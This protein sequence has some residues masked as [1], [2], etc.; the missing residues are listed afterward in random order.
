MSIKILSEKIFFQKPIIFHHFVIW[1]EMF[2]LK[3]YR[4]VHKSRFYVCVGKLWRKKN[5]FEKIFY[6]PLAWWENLSAFCQNFFRRG[7]GNDN[8]FSE[9]KLFWKLQRFFHNFETLIDF[10][11]G[12]WHFIS[13]GLSKLHFTCPW[14]IFDEKK[15]GKFEF[16]HYSEFLNE[17]SSRF[18]R[19]LFAWFVKTAFYVSIGNLNEN[20]FCTK[21]LYFV[22]LGYWANISAPWLEIF[23]RCSRNCLLCV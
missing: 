15:L 3:I 9:Q 7:C 16:F 2:S 4:Q 22:I 12:F 11:P 10:F 5:I 18:F 19:I 13:A 6:H 21:Y 14:K 23:Q 1:N 20:F 17:N 8:V